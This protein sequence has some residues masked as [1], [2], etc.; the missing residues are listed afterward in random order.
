MDPTNAQRQARH[1]ARTAYMATVAPRA[2][3]VRGV[4][5]DLVA[6][7]RGGFSKATDVAAELWPLHHEVPVFHR[8]ASSPATMSASPDLVVNAM[9]D[10]IANLGVQ[11]AGPRLLSHPSALQFRFDR[12]GSVT[13]PVSIPTSTD[14]S[15]FPGEG[16][17]IPVGE[18]STASGV[19]LVPS[20]VKVIRAYNRE[21][22]NA[23]TPNIERVI[24]ASLNG[25]VGPM[26][27]SYLLSTNAATA[28]A[29]MGIRFG[30]AE[31]DAREHGERRRGLQN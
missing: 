22:F 30:V 14:L 11:Y 17:V 7:A 13:F 3:V 1:R 9:G 31:Y 4:M 8:A 10:F 26:V 2:V 6:R 21:V 19:S 12:F 15:S 20:K 24:T 18:T 29:P 16:G 27:D 25:A 28:T 5:A 23:S